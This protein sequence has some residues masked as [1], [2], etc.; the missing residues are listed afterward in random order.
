LR[1]DAGSTGRYHQSGCSLARVAATVKASVES[2]GDDMTQDRNAFRDPQHIPLWSLL[3]LL[4]GRLG[5]DVAVAENIALGKP[6]EWSTPPRYGECSDKGDTTQLTD[7][8]SKGG[9]WH[10]KSTV[11]S[12]G[13]LQDRSKWYS[14]RFE[15]A[16]LGMR[17]RYVRLVFQAEERYFFLDEW[18]WPRLSLQVGLPNQ[19]SRRRTQVDG[20]KGTIS[21]PR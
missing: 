12:G 19:R 13:P 8:I 15:T 5:T 9:S 6:Y 16:A 21:I 14:H 20:P 10:E 17:G 4:G 7:G 18:S 3:L 1:I 2:E 11:G